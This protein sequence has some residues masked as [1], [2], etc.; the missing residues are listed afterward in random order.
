MAMNLQEVRDLITH[1]KSELRKIDFQK[2]KI[3]E[4]LNSLKKDEKKIADKEHKLSKKKTS[5]ATNK[6]SKEKGHSTKI[7]TIESSTIA[8][9]KKD[10]NRLLKKSTTGRK[11]SKSKAAPTKVVRIVQAVG[12]DLVKSDTQLTKTKAPKGSNYRLSDWDSYLVDKIKD[13]DELLTRAE[14]NALF[15]EKAAQVGGM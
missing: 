4:T 6:L 2:T 11:T 5:K 9:V 13:A 15:E 12:G 7:R 3:E 10:P 1:Y 14:I 8:K